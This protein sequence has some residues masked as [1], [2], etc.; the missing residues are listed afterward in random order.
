MQDHVFLRFGGL[1]VIKHNHRMEGKAECGLAEDLMYCGKIAKFAENKIG[2]MKVVVAPDTYKGT[3]SAGEAAGAMASGVR[4]I[5]PEAEVV[6]MPVGDGGEGTVEAI[7]RGRRSGEWELRRCETV[8][9]LG[10]EIEAEYAVLELEGRATALIESAAASGLTL[11]SREERDVMRAD[12]FGTGVLIADAYRQGIRDF[13]ICMGGS[14]TC[15]G[16]SGAYRAL[17]GLDMKQ[18]RFTLLCDVENPLCGPRG[19]AAVFGPQK[20]A[21]TD[22]IPILDNHLRELARKYSML[23]GI[24]VTDMKCAGAAGGL[25]GML[26]ACYGARPVSGIRKVLELIEFEKRIYGGDLVITG[27]GRVDATTL[28][29]K[30]P[31]GILEASKRSGVPVAV[32]GGQ[33][34]DRGTLEEAGFAYI[35]TADG[36]AGRALKVLQDAARN[37]MLKFK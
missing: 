22:Q 3:M 16:G 26:M 27:E 17:K 12:T 32:I 29:G 33:V 13:M 20:G 8:N 5:V 2:I 30:A 21:T 19:A 36:R 25:A 14:A 18:A 6:E 24:D 10:R 28:S 11:L 37:L 9:A 1:N 23:H 4:E 31:I 34:A 35:E 7:L 15:D